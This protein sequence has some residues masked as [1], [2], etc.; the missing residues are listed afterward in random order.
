MRV[1]LPNAKRVAAVMSKL[2]ISTGCASARRGA[3]IERNRRMARA[4]TDRRGR[5]PPSSTLV[6]VYGVG[7]CAGD[8]VG[9]AHVRGCG[10][11]GWLVPSVLSVCPCRT[12][13]TGVRRRD[14]PQRKH[15]VAVCSRHCF[16]SEGWVGGALLCAAAR[17]SLP[18][19]PTGSST[20]RRLSSI[21]ASFGFSAFATLA[22][23]R[24]SASPSC[25]SPRSSAALPLRVGTY[26][27]S[28]ACCC[29]LRP[30]P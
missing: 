10:L 7:A 14:R 30:P 18:T 17:R 8:R 16:A 22:F 3:R 28:T 4:S 27:S 15:C 6:V 19:A 9:L 12:S 26:W 23:C 20:S 13:R 21:S 25:R 5:G 11:R 24:S 29:R 1:H 2:S